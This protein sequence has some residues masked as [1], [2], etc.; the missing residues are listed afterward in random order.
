MVVVQQA[1]PYSYMT[2]LDKM[3]NIHGI[4]IKQKPQFMEQMS[5]CEID[6]IYNV[7][8]CDKDGDKKKS[9][10]LFKCK[11]K[12]GCCAKQCMRPDSRPFEMHVNHENKD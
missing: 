1:N 9:L 4:F 8:A 6:N 3:K 2:A 7:Y 11:E 12:S 5:G 10:K